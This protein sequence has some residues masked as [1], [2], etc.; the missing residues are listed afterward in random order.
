MDWSFSMGWFVGL[1]TDLRCSHA[2]MSDLDL[3]C[4]VPVECSL[5]DKEFDFRLQSSSG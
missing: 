3:A 4:S 2:D 5:L 1:G